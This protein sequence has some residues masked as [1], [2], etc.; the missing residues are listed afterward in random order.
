MSPTAAHK[1]SFPIRFWIGL[2]L[3]AVAWVLNWGLEGLRTHW[4]FFP[5]WLGYCLVVDGWVFQRCGTSL[6]HRS[7]LRYAGLFLLSIPV[8]WLFEVL[9]LVTQNWSYLG[10]E[11]FT[12]LE[13]FLF[14]SLSFSTV[15]PAV[16]GTAELLLTVG[17]IKN[18]KG[19]WNCQ[20]GRN[21][22][23]G[24]CA[25]GWI[26]LGLMLAFPRIFFPLMWLSVFFILDPLNALRG[27]PS[28]IRQVAYG[29][30]SNTIAFGLGALVCG[31]FWEMWNIY[32]YPKWIYSIPYLEVLHVFEMPLAG[33]GG[34]IPFGWELFAIG[35][36][37]GS[38]RNSNPNRTESGAFQSADNC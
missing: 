4:L 36:L 1:G 27:R 15:I 29:T 25:S 7:R 6:I 31:F 30:L 14:S 8:W 17:W 5:Q 28:L 2:V 24:L 11:S 32:A 9:N 38:I 22:L 35:A 23:L 20:L 21:L 13:Y 18:L 26:M 16:F 34:Y 3:V 10:R 37:A 19:R 12:D 33:Y